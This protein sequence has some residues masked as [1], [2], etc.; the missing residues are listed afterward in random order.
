M[1]RRAVFILDRVV[2]EKM[3]GGVDLEK[4]VWYVPEPG[5]QIQAANRRCCLWRGN[6][7]LQCIGSFLN[8]LIRTI[9][10]VKFCRLQK[11]N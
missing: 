8:Y 7:S 10:P 6:G 3:G 2:Q 5:I 4:N 9:L 1:A 11:Y